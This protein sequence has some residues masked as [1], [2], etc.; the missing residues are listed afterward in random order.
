[1][2]EI[3]QKIISCSNGHYYDANKYASCPYCANPSTF[4]K[5][6][7]PLGEP[8]AAFEGGQTYDPYGAQGGF[9]PTIDPTPGNASYSSV[10]PTEA[11][12]KR[13][14]SSGRMR[15][16]QF[17]DVDAP[18]LPTPVVG[19]LVETEGKLRGT[20]YK[21]H[22]GYNYIGRGAGDICLREDDTVSFEND[23]AVSFVPQTGQ[24]YIS[25]LQ[26]KNVVLL[27]NAPVPVVGAELHNYDMITIGRTKL[28]FIGLCGEQFS[29]KA[30]GEPQ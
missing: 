2:A 26:G 18:N 17:V 19:W 11:A 6:S 20:D 29:W 14:A 30:E 23:S 13:E 15:Q 3:R 27:N 7:D 28:I 9:S 10:P 21:L 24:F 5:T 8:R 1:M 12:P 4:P 22:T 25:H 16:T